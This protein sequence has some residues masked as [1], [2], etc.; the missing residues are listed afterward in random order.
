MSTKEAYRAELKEVLAGF[1]RNL[2]R[3]REGEEYSQEVL[4]LDA[5]LDRT[6]ISKYERGLTDPPL[7]VLLILADTLSCT[8]NDLVEGLPVPKERRPSPKA[9]HRRAAG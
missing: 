8:L 3:R 7:S 2:R 1:G 9:E 6:S 4:R 5:K